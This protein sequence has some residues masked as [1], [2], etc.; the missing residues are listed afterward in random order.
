MTDA[1]DRVRAH[2]DGPGLVDRIKTALSAIAP[3]DQPLTVPQLAMLDQFHT[4][5]I[6]A[7]A[8]LAGAAGLK[9]ADKVL[10]LGCG[11]GGP[12]RYLATMFGC[13]VTG[14]DLSP[15]FVEAAEYLTARCG[16]ADR[17]AFKVGDALHLPF[18]DGAFDAVFL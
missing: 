17:V 1:T 7:T 5:G 9:A 10:D 12:A 2:Y 6:L 16:L 15:S 3:E 8:E 13:S 4:R 18:D 11:I 14:V